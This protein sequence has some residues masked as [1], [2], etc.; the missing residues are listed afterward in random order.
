MSYTHENHMLHTLVGEGLIFLCVTDLN[1]QRQV[2]FGF[3]E[4]VAKRFF[5]AFPPGSRMPEPWKV[6]VEQKPIIEALMSKT[7]NV[8]GG[9]VKAARAR[10]ALEDLKEDMMGNIEKVIDRGE[11]IESLVDKSEGLAERSLSFKQS[12]ARL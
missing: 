10:N 1:C 11:N 3:L 4:E 7:N 8:S 9:D 5:S 2:A 6:S 12:S